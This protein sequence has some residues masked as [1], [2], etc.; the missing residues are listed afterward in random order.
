MGGEIY[1]NTGKDFPFCFSHKNVRLSVVWWCMPLV[2]VLGDKGRQSSELKV[3]FINSQDYRET[4][5][6]RTNKNYG[7]RLQMFKVNKL[8]LLWVSADLRGDPALRPR[9]ASISR[10]P[11]ILVQPPK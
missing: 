1:K 4:R 9:L 8:G 11:E 10:S 3:S 6:K 5:L 7:T 2:P